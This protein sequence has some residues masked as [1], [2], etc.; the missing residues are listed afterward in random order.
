MED[1]EMSGMHKYG[2]SK[3]TRI[4]MATVRHV[5]SGSGRRKFQVTWFLLDRAYKNEYEELMDKGKLKRPEINVS[6]CYIAYHTI[7]MAYPITEPLKAW[8][9]RTRNPLKFGSELLSQQ[10]IGTRG[11]R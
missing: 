7:H 4:M 6:H 10:K 8:Y 3:T 5:T 2:E 1:R 11:I 9:S